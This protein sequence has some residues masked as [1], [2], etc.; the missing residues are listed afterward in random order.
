RGD[1]GHA[2]PLSRGRDLR[3]ADPCARTGPEITPPEKVILEKIRNPRRSRRRRP[4]LAEAR[5]ENG[6]G[7]GGRGPTGNPKF[8]NSRPD[9]SA[10]S[11]DRPHSP[12]LWTT[13]GARQRSRPVLPQ[14]RA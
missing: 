2:N 6:S 8:D 9:A 7:D 13:R 11:R 10:G 5:R 12:P 14:H 4:R 1:G 3:G